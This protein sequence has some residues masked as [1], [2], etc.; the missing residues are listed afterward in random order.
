M[1][2]TCFMSRLPALGKYRSKSHSLPGFI[3][4]SH[5]GLYIFNIL[6]FSLGNQSRIRRWMVDLNTAES[7]L[8]DLNPCIT[9][10]IHKNNNTMY[11]PGP[12]WP[13]MVINTNQSE[14]TAQECSPLIRTNCSWTVDVGF[15][16]NL[17]VI[18]QCKWLPDIKQSYCYH[19]NL[20]ITY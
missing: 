16:D 4:G 12:A 3:T 17:W 11:R 7:K 9:D 19:I 8:T 20:N 15:C 13:L 6:A 14:L 2:E 18:H 10:R 1:S 5:G